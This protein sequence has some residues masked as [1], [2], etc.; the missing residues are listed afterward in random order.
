MSGMQVSP[1][2]IEETL[3]QHSEGLIID[4]TVAGVSGG[5]TADERVPRAWVVLSPHG[6]ALGPTEVVARLDAW[7][8][9]KLS[10]Y[11]WLRGGIGVV[12]QVRIP[13]YCSGS[14]LLTACI[15]AV[16]TQIAHGQGV[17]PGVGGRVRG[18]CAIAY[19]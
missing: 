13:F 4:V 15:A 6:Q 3:L 1:T 7:V 9:D 17:A 5:R 18:S 10:R 2:E 12:N 19:G 14:Q 11:K 8:R 16:D